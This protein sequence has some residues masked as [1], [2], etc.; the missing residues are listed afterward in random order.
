LKVE[1]LFPQD[2]SLRALVKGVGYRCE[3]RRKKRKICCFLTKKFE[4]YIN[5]VS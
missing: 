1:A 4:A 2:G 5:V 3:A